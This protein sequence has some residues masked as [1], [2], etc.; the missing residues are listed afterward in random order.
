MVEFRPQDP[1][2]REAVRASFAKQGIMKTIGARMGEVGPGTCDILL[3][4]RCGLSQQD[5]YFHGGVICTIGDSAA[6]YAAMTLSPPGGRVLSVEY[7]FNFM[8]PADGERLI[9]RGR[10]IRAG[11]TLVVCKSDVFVIKDGVEIQCAAS[12]Q[13]IIN[14]GSEPAA[15]G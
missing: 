14:F 7:K 11:R 1:D 3:D 9:A 12:L 10:V 15:G 6:G 8:A 13:T 5:G 2:Y 4:Y